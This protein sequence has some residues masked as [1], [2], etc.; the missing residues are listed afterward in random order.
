MFLLLLSPDTHTHSPTAADTI[1]VVI[2]YL[3][4]LRNA[5]L[6]WELLLCMKIIIHKAHLSAGFV[7]HCKHLSAPVELFVCCVCLCGLNR[8]FWFCVLCVSVYMSVCV[9]CES[10]HASARIQRVRCPSGFTLEWKPKGSDFSPRSSV[11][12]RGPQRLKFTL[13]R[14]GEGRTGLARLPYTHILFLKNK[15]TMKIPLVSFP[16]S[17]TLITL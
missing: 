11:K 16:P 2:L 8:C 13:L 14:H 10:L 3:L 5:C 15:I 4:M 7:C 1:D 17:R 12:L 6:K 9:L